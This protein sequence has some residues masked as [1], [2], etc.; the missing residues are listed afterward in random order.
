[1]S[2]DTPKPKRENFYSRLRGTG[3]HQGILVNILIVN[4]FY[5]IFGEGFR[6]LLI[7]YASG[8]WTEYQYGIILAV[9]GYAAMGFVFILGIVVDIQFKRTTMIIGIIFTIASALIFSR[10]T[11]FG[12]SITFYALFAVGQQL[13]MISTSTFIANETKKGQHRTFGF[14]GNQ[15]TRGV[16]NAIA[17]IISMYLL[18]IPGIDYTWAFTIITVFAVVSLIL[19]FTLKLVAEES[20]KAE[21]EYAEKLSEE[22]EDDFTKYSK[23]KDGKRSILGVQASFGIGRMLMGFTSGVAIP[24]VGWYVYTSF[25]EGVYTET[26]ANEIWGWINCI[27]WIVLTLGYLLMGVFAEKIGKSKIVVIFWTLVIPA[28]V[29]IWLAQSLLVVVTFYI[30]RSFFAM[31]PGAAWNSFLYEWIPPK[32]R[33]KT[34]GLLQTGQRGMRSTGT[35]LGGLAFATFGAALFPI[36]MTAYP[37]AGLFPLI[38]SYIVKRRLKKQLGEAPEAELIKTEEDFVPI[39]PIMETRP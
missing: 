1:M 7:P 2:E 25:L 6:V 27:H 22:S 19:V 14:T 36:A 26:A 38:Q 4:F 11:I 32:H 31:T 3:S 35:L 9:G 20:P 17:P 30:M 39:E 13:M 15:A 5:R 24:F 33:G 34:L 12:L 8:I 29:G 18:K 23:T 10:M 21:I 28:A 37:I 16:A